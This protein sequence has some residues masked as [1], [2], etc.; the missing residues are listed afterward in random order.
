PVESAFDGHKV[1]RLSLPGF[2]DEDLQ[3]PYTIEKLAQH[4]WDL[5]NADGETLVH[6]VGHSMGGYVCMEMVA[7]HPNRV[8]SLCLLHSHVFA[9]SDEKKKAR[10]VV[11]EEIQS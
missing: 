7:Q 6:L 4:Y 11:L 3:G 9:D 10:S 5:L 2:G 1:I 8:A